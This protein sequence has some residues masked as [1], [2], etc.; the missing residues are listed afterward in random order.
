[1]NIVLKTIVGF[2][3]II[4]LAISEFIDDNA[5]QFGASLSFYTLFAAAPIIIIVISLA[6]VFYGTEAV[7]GKIYG[8]IN[9]L[10]GHGAAIQIQEIIKN[11]ETHKQG[12]IGALIGIII[13]LVAATGVFTEI[14]Y[15]VNYMW[16][17]KAKPKKGWLKILKNRLLSFSLIIGLGFILLIS[18]VV[19]ALLDLVSEKVFHSMTNS[20]GFIFQV[21]N[22]AILFA[23]T[24]SLFA[25]IFK[26][27]PDATIWWRDSFIGACFTSFLFLIGKY[28]IGFYLANSTMTANFGGAAS[29]VI[30]L[31]WVYYS[32]NILFF[33]A[34]FTKIYAM[35]YGGGIVPDDT[36]VFI[37]KQEAKEINVASV[38]L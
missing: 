4:K 29:M 34:E 25:I 30:I 24:T 26:V 37:I 36:A 8:Q 28:L 9:G 18:L 13:L 16:A 23:V 5:V 21:F 20:N 11:I 3:K 33:G 15:S 35:Q 19:S 10:V 2:Y 14:Q 22:S 32:S 17:I 6:G 31:L 7:Q 1:M 12:T 27:L 38:S